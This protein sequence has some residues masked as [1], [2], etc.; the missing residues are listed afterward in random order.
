MIPTDIFSSPQS[1]VTANE[2]R[3]LIENPESVQNVFFVFGAYDAVDKGYLHDGMWHSKIGLEDIMRNYPNNR[4]DKYRLDIGNL[5]DT[6]GALLSEDE[7]TEL[8]KYPLDFLIQEILV[9]QAHNT[10]STGQIVAQL[11]KCG[12]EYIRNI[13]RN[14][15]S[16]LVT[17]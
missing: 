3:W 4:K 13:M 6:V 17:L 15:L 2:L 10:Y 16:H 12:K 7:F 11:R 14:K 8:A 9:Q 5:F 1:G